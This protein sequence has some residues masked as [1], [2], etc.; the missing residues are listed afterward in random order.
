MK[1]Q[2]HRPLGRM[3]A[4]A[5]LAHALW[6]NASRA[7]LAG[8]YTI[9]GA[10][11][12]YATFTAAVTALSASGVAG[13]VDFRVRPGTYTEQLDIPLVAGTSAAAG[14]LFQS[15]TG[16]AAS[17]VLQFAASSAANNFVVRLSGTHHVRFARMTF[18]SAGFGAGFR[19]LVTLKGPVDDIQ[20][21]ENVFSGF[22]G[23]GY[24]DPDRAAIFAGGDTLSNVAITGNSF[25]GG[26]YA[27]YLKGLS[28]LLAAGTQV[29]GNTV[30]SLTNGIFLNLHDSPVV[31]R[32]VVS[33]SYEGIGLYSCRGPLVVRKNKVEVHT[34]GG[35]TFTDCIAATLSRGL[36]ANN[37]IVVREIANGLYVFSGRYLDF[38]Y[39]TV[40]NNGSAVSGV[41][42]YEA[43]GSSGSIDVV[44]NMFI[45]TG[46]GYAYYA[47]APAGIGTSEFNDL[48]V[49][50]TWIARWGGVDQVDLAA[51]RAASGKDLQSVSRDVTFTSSVDL[52]LAGASL[53]DTVLRGTPFGGVPDDI[54]GEVRDPLGPYMGADEA[55]RSPLT[56]VEGEVV[57]RGVVLRQNRP[58]PFNPLTT[59]GYA[60]PTRAHVTL[61]VYDSRGAQVARLVDRVE[62]AGEKTV[63]FDARGLGSGVYL[64]RIAV[65]ISGSG[66]RP[67]FAATRKLTVIK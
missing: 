64:Y 41:P 11:P 40:L 46:L 8:T 30:G 39:N 4:C 66:G 50:G 26:S 29:A 48:H 19:R 45:N 51:L 62:D 55:P 65:E 7:Q 47:S 23:A 38:Y 16:N 43:G 14:I 56:A 44:D 31:E 12:S 10:S 24:T 5:I 33:T 61:R 28:N 15:E 37:F 1:P 36:I 27:V 17:V 67:A 42:F 49:L 22:G 9:G 53:G 13:P 58:N 25:T 57:S 54:D 3:L 32:N 20:F 59:I 34:G 21:N 6:T 63:E 60:V 52:H 2:H 18:S 35:I